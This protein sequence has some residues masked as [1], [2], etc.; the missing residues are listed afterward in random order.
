MQPLRSLLAAAFA[1]CA[2]AL[3]AYALDKITISDV[4]TGSST[5]W[6][7][8]IAMDKGF[9]KDAGVEIEYVGV[10]SSSAAMQQV[11]A[12]AVNMT[13]GGLVDALRAIDK[14]APAKLVRTEAGPSIYEV[15][16]RPEI[17]SF[18]DLR[19]KTVMIGG[20]KD[21]TRIYFEEM[22]T[23]N[24]VKPGEYDYIFAGAT[25]A[26]FGALAS[27][28]IAATILTPP[29]NFKAAGAGYA[30][31]GTS[32]DYSKGFPFT[33]Y[34]ANVRWAEKNKPAIQ[35]FSAAYARGVEWFYQPENRAE[36]IAILVKYS[37]G[38]PEDVAN[39]YDFYVKLKTFSHDGDMA[40]SG[41]QN[42][43]G[44]LKKDGDLEGAADLPRFYD[45]SL[46]GR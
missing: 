30:K 8:F 10:P 24:G 1:L 12:S 7:M 27:G 26:R 42:L 18:A 25:A 31:L 46:V 20:I 35:G 37:K 15:Y 6:P 13:V 19:K 22:A 32:A 16:A 23:A 36:A 45:A 5:H 41:I 9:A 44:I 38:A 4:G 40:E 21:V 39:T 33:G 28:S 43:I 14:G 34:S 17:K 11:A 2:G 3:P 29:F